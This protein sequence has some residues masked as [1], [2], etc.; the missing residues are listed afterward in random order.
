MAEKLILNILKAK[1]AADVLPVS[2]TTLYRLAS[3]PD[4][5]YKDAF[6]FLGGSL[7]VDL[8]KF[9]EIGRKEA[10]KRSLMR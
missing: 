4:S 8:N 10:Q 9:L 7:C 6:L 3:N 2:Y 5:P 1:K